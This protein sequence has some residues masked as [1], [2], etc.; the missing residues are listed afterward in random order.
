M[1]TGTANQMEVGKAL[2]NAVTKLHNGAV[3]LLHAVSQTNTEMLGN[4]IDK[5]R[6]KGFEIKSYN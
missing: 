3:Y 6:E 2:D 4:F 1:Q 5:A